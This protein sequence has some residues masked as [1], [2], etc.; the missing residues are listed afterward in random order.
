MTIHQLTTHGSRLT[1]CRLKVPPAI[2]MKPTATSWNDGAGPPLGI[3]VDCCPVPDDLAPPPPSS[4]R[5]AALQR[6]SVVATPRR[7]GEPQRVGN[8][9]V[10]RDG[11]ISC[12]LGS[13]PSD[14][15]LTLVPA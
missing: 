2:D 12:Y 8:A 1:R 10:N 11:T 15:K 14:G 5:P 6:F 9:V 3:C 13:L 4:P 7:G